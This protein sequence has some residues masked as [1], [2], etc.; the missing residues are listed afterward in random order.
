MLPLA[1]VTVGLARDFIVFLKDNEDRKLKIREG[2]SMKVQPLDTVIGVD[3]EK[4]P[5]PF[6][7]EIRWTWYRRLQVRSLSIIEKREFP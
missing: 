3:S 6:G 5:Y 4:A 2:N 7:F 1:L